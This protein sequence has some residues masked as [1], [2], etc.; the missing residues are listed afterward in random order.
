MPG[1]EKN[2]SVRAGRVAPGRLGRRDL[3]EPRSLK[4]LTLT[5]GWAG[6]GVC[7]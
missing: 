2:S 6:T 5:Y 4:V 1:S 3:D 7:W